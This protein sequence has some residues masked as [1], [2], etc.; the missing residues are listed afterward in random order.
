MRSEQNAWIWL[1]LLTLLPVSPLLVQTHVLLQHDY[2]L[3]DLHHSHLPMRAFF[4]AEIAGG[5]LPLWWPDVYSGVPFWAQIEAGILWLPQWFFFGLFDPYVGFNFLVGFHVLL[6]AAGAWFLCRSLGVGALPAALG[7]IVF[8][9]CGFN[10][11]HIRNPNLHAAAAMLPWVLWALECAL[12]RGGGRRW[13]LLGLMIGLQN[14]AGMPQLTYYTLL[15]VGA[16]WLWELGAL[17]LETGRLPRWQDALGF[18]IACVA[19]M[20]VAAA[21]LLPT[22]LFNQYTVRAGGL[23][24]DQISLGGFNHWDFIAL[25]FPPASGDSY[26]LTYRGGSSSWN[27]Y[28]Y[29]GLLPFAL[30]IVGILRGENRRLAGFLLVGAPLVL[31]LVIGTNNPLFYWIWHWLPGMDLFRRPARFLLLFDLGV[32]VGAAAGLAVLMERWPERARSLALAVVLISVLD[33]SFFSRPHLPLEPMD[34]WANPAPAVQRLLEQDKVSRAHLLE[35]YVLWSGAFHD[36]SGFKSRGHLPFRALAGLPLGS[37]GSV[38]G[39]R[40][41]G[42]YVVLTS[43][44]VS[45]YWMRYPTYHQFVGARYQPDIW[46]EGELSP[47]FH[48]L[49]R[50]AAVS[51]VI[52]HRALNGPFQS[53][54]DGVFSDEDALPRSYLATYW[55]AQ[56]DRHAV[57]RWLL[58]EGM[59]FPQVPGIEG[60]AEPPVSSSSEGTVAVLVNEISDSLL[61]QDVSQ[62]GAGW[63]VLSD[64]WDPGWTVEVDGK[65]EAVHVANG[66]QRAVHIAADAKTVRWTYWPIGLTIGLW[67]SGLSS[68]VLAMLPFF[69]RGDRPLSNT[70]DS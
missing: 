50:R 17:R 11:A 4:G 54:G 38:H 52:S 19:G 58:G 20:G 48:G 15:V 2:F 70:A 23:T 28:A 65:P 43:Q 68:L 25:L 29:C 35:D 7:G 21:V 41:P 49:L 51:Y 37:A 26:L 61:V 39:L 62:V 36:N 30:A 57:G 63:L 1:I 6:S 44:R 47:A 66:F 56:P 8:G 18:G 32:A 59:R 10:L 27:T 64:A 31:S 24:W 55:V 5:H 60:A 13:A 22:W 34:S 12:K 69:L 45:E 42:G 40:S 67:L 9:L 16:R 14:L 33:L 53:L 3:S 46:E